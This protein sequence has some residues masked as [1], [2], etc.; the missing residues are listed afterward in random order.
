MFPSPGIDPQIPGA[1]DNCITIVLHSRSFECF[2]HSA[3][4]PHL[5]LKKS[6]I[7]LQTNIKR[8]VLDYRPTHPEYNSKLGGSQTFDP[9]THPGAPTQT[10]PPPKL[11]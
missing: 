5:K 1:I 3:D 8:G 2:S 4:C 7:S 6:A 9:P 10:P 11:S